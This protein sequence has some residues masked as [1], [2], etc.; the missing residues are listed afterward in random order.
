MS[1]VSKKKKKKWIK[2]YYGQ[3]QQRNIVF[4]KNKIRNTSNFI[5]HFFFFNEM[6]TVAHKRKE[7]TNCFKIQFS[8]VVGRIYKQTF[9]RNE[10]TL[11]MFSMMP[12][13]EA[14][15]TPKIWMLKAPILRWS[16]FSAAIVTKNSAAHNSENASLEKYILILIKFKLT[17]LKKK[18]YL[19]FYTHCRCR[20]AWVL[21][22]TILYSIGRAVHSDVGWTEGKWLQLQQLCSIYKHY[23]IFTTSK[24]LVA[25][26]QSLSDQ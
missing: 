12:G 16:L 23:F 6:K 3:T 19:S 22:M 25:F 15:L 9:S 24:V 20:H 10:P 18:I 8:V 1:L 2:W 13:L 26:R 7:Y 21:W 17:M 5:L 4:V 11:T 14:F